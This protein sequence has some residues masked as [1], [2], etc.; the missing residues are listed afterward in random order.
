MKRTEVKE[1]LD[2]YAVCQMQALVLAKDAGAV[3]EEIQNRLQKFELIKQFLDML[4]FEDNA[5][6][7]AVYIEKK[8]VTRLAKERGFA[9]SSIYKRLEKA[10]N[11]IA[12]SIPFS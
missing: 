6:I 4:P 7:R 12:E 1:I 11:L 9:R 3:S 8:S 10:I 2:N 5:L